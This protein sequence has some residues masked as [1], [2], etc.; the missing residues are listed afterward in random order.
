M[1]P[2][3]TLR[4]QPAN[5]LLTPSTT[6]MR[7]PLSRTSNGVDIWA[8]T[9]G[10]RWILGLVAIANLEIVWFPYS[11]DLNDGRTDYRA[12]TRQMQQG[13]LQCLYH[14]APQATL[15]NF[16]MRSRGIAGA[17]DLQSSSSRSILDLTCHDKIST[18]HGQATHVP[19]DDIG[20]AIVENVAEEDWHAEKFISKLG[21]P[22]L[23][24]L[25]IWVEEQYPTSEDPQIDGVHMVSVREQVGNW[26]NSIIS[27]LQKK[28]SW[29]AMHGIRLI[30]FRLGLIS[31]GCNICGFILKRRG[32]AKNGNPLRQWK[33][34]IGWEPISVQV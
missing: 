34:P 16:R 11:L 8:D 31:K 23:V 24:D 21:A 22:E 2:S 13:L 32:K 17:A 26:R 10:R 5:R 1:R 25:F 12:Q 3:P 6:G 27:E 30:L 29:E 18:A 33:F 20:Q 7:Q 14:F 15:N 4:T 9:Q 28:D 19:E